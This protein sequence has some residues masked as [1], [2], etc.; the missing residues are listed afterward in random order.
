MDRLVMLERFVAARPDD[1]FAR[2]G[3][4]MELRKRG[5]LARA[6]QVFAELIERH[7]DYVPTYLMAGGCLL[8]AGDRAGARA[9]FERGVA[10]ATAAGDAHARG[11]LEAARA[12]LD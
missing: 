4:A 10:V 8:E 3:L 9:V 11:E 1:P 6:Q 7:P 2:Y 12:E 5:E